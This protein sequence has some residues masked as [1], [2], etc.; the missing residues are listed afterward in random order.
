MANIFHG[1]K[2][3]SQEKCVLLLAPLL[4]FEIQTQTREKYSLSKGSVLDGI[5]IAFSL[6]TLFMTTLS[7]LV[8]CLISE[9]KVLVTLSPKNVLGMWVAG[10]D[11]PLI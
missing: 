1:T 11:Q 3:A 5:W 8:K 7:N 9:N 2:G 6:P 4:L 10:W